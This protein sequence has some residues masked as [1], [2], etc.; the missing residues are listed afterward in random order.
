MSF[1]P[2]RRLAVAAILLWVLACTS[3]ASWARSTSPVP[4]AA[5]STVVGNFRQL[6]GTV[7][8]VTLTGRTSGSVWGSG[9]YTFDSDMATA[10]V[11]AGV[12]VVGESKTVK[13]SIV[14]G[15]SSYTG[16][17]RNGVTSSSYGTYTGGSY[18]LE[19]DD[20]GDN[21]ILQDPG[22]LR[23]FELGLG[24]VHRFKVTG[25]AKG[26]SVWGTNAYTSDSALAVAAVHSGVLLD[27]Q[28][29]VVR[30][31][32]VPPQAIYA[33]STA[34]GITSNDYGQYAGAYA[35]SNVAGTVA[36]TAYPGMLSNPLPNP[37]SL[38]AYRGR[39]LA[40]QHFNVTGSLSGGVWGT[41]IY[42]DDSNLA[43]A[44][45]HAGV[46][47]AGQQGVVKV[48]IRPGLTSSPTQG[49]AYVG[50]TAHGITSNSYGTY[51][52][53]FSVVNPDG[54]LGA[55]PRVT[56][57]GAV[58]AELNQSFRFQMNTSPAA[59]SYNATGLPAGL[60]V[61]PVT[62]L[63]SG[64]PMISGSFPIQL[65]VTNSSGTSN[66]GLLIKVPATPTTGF[67]PSF[68]SLIGPEILQS[69]GKATIA[70]TV[71]FTD[72]SLRS[73]N[74]VWT[75]SN[76]A[77]ATVS[78]AGVLSAGLVKAD[79]PVSLTAI[80][81]EGGVTVTATLQL[82][83]TAAPAVLVGVR[84]V[85]ADSVQ[86]G[87][88][89]RLTLAALYSDGS[90]RSVVPSA[91]TLSS[92]ALGSVNS[93]GVLTVASVDADTVL[94]ISASYTEKGI[95]KNTSLALSIVATP[96]VLSRLTLIG[97]RGTLGS[98]ESLN[99]AAAGVYVD[100]SRKPVQALWAVKG[101]AATISSAGVLTAKAVSQDS[102]CVVIAS[103]TEAGVTVNAHFQVLVQ[104]I[105][106][107]T[108][109]QA[110]VETTGS[111]ADFGLSVWSTANGNTT[112][113]A[114]PATVASRGGTQIAA[115]DQASYQLFVIAVVPAGSA[116]AS[117]TGFML[118]RNSEWQLAGFPLAEYLSGVADNSYQLIEIF[119]HLD[120]SLISG[121]QIFVGYGITDTEM[122][123]SGRYRMVYQVQ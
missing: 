55:I 69:G 49:N 109:V 120:A 123:E 80:Y 32:V 110:E 85:G 29:G 97:A 20:G 14:T 16:S 44:A 79:T 17:V 73:V 12:V 68:L 91:Y 105:V 39:N 54:G 41:G 59:T 67:T 96:A 33:G 93:R 116:V 61:D 11:H 8:Y 103:Y 64:I 10:A 57:G 98:N 56:N 75:S 35:V 119:D 19:A 15:Q 51:A 6:P 3:V 52:G 50:S 89:I 86:S 30:V 23:T 5:V 26:G 90:I 18:R 47:A 70:A 121:T 7:V 42:T 92:V 117:T 101:N 58:N 22:S 84:L 95:S 108:P 4:E 53:S 65:L 71:R 1:A 74:P 76:P 60:A 111:Q 13:L 88:Q 83:V 34:N 77:A 36:L 82:T 81:T 24:G 25:S 66:A 104:A 112:V 72:S 48:I 106:A 38:T 9:P 107:P 118:N 28:T 78:A 62:G 43:A 102:P 99:L 87:G 100:G 31:V 63:I 40:A 2:S 21:P 46:L 27:G 114:G 113:M 37:G 115:T 45:V 122:L 94:T